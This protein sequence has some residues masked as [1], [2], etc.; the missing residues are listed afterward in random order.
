M[1]RSPDSRTQQDSGN[2]GGSLSTKRE[3]NDT[4]KTSSYASRKVILPPNSTTSTSNGACSSNEL[5]E[6]NKPSPQSFPRNNSTPVH[7]T[8]PGLINEIL[9]K[10]KMMT[11]EELCNAVLPVLLCLLTE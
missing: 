10:S 8:L 7:Q 1:R 3:E 2:I 11:Y 4:Q 9:S 5:N 6:H